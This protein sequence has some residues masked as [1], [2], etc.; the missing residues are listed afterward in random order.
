M[1][2]RVINYYKEGDV[3]VVTMDDGKANAIQDNFCQEMISTLEHAKKDGVKALVLMGK[4]RIYCG[5]L[6]LKTLPRL[7]PEE[8]QGTLENFY[9]MIDALFCFPAPVIAAGTG[10]ALAGGFILYLCCDYRCAIDND[11]HRYGL[12]EMV[13]GLP[14]SHWTLAV[15]EHAI[16]NAVR[17]ELILRARIMSPKETLKLG[18]THHLAGSHEEVLTLALKHAA[19]QGERLVPKAVGITKARM[20]RPALQTGWER[21][22]QEIAGKPLENRFAHLAR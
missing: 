4:E 12:N 20:R 7:T 10:H 3:G 15:V 2:S 13:N 17:D 1:P 9:K 18:I 6:D 5:G 16:P 22:Q 14:I 8:L 21:D 19:A 11:D